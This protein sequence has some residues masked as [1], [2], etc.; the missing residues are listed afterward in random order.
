MGVGWDEVYCSS[1]EWILS[2]SDNE[3]ALI[4]EAN[5]WITSL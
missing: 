3:L 2:M 5:D 4:F 1:S